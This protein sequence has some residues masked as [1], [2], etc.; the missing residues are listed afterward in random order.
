MDLEQFEQITSIISHF[1]IITAMIGLIV[2]V[3]Q[4]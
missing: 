2:Q 3:K 1:T 4:N